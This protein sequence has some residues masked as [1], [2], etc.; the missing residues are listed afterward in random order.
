M[1]QDANRKNRWQPLKS[2]KQK[3]SK[4]LLQYGAKPSNRLKGPVP[5]LPFRR[6]EVHA[7]EED[8]P[9]GEYMPLA[10]R[11]GCRMYSVLSTYRKSP[12]ISSS[13]S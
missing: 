8:L 6:V 13:K 1:I 11:T 5:D 9:D 3:R 4:T 7:D 12:R 2:K 10:F